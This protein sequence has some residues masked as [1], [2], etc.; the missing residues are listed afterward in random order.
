MKA[1][2]EYKRENIKV[3]LS[4]IALNLSQSTVMFL[5]FFINLMLVTHTII[6]G[7]GTVSDL[8]LINMY[9]MQVYQP[10]NNLGFMWR[11]IR[12]NMVDVSQVFELLEVDSSIP[13]PKFPEICRMKFGE[14]EF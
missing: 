1:L 14:I 9:I 5:C 8:I 10:L 4:M 6:S 2:Q 3:T 7:R 13:E 12:Q 11:S